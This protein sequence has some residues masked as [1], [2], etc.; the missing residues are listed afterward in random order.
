MS[1]KVNCYVCGKNL[2]HNEVGL[3]R[4][5]IRRDI[6]KF[7]CLQCLADFMEL[8]VEEL[9]DHIQNFKDAGCVLFE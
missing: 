7:H 1:K 9:E 2:T 4:K 3:N 8:S 5:L 6:D